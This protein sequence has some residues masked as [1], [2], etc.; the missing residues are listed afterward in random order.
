MP[1]RSGRD[2]R[3]AEERQR[4]LLEE[5][6][7]SLARP[8]APLAPLQD[9][10]LVGFKLGGESWALESRFVWAA[11][12]AQHLVPLPGAAPPIAGV[13]AWRGSV[14]SVLDLRGALGV[15]VH[16]PADLSHMLVLGDSQPQFGLLV[17]SLAEVG[18][19]ARE[20][21][22]EPPARNVLH[23]EWILGVTPSGALALDGD[24][25]IRQLAA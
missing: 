18:R 4:T 6:A 10:T 23:R 20:A 24:R 16:G 12:R 2:S 7:R 14:L 11:F 9:L 17:D 25:L 19:F 22:A 15:Q 21:L 13:S 3:A 5:R 8:P 1:W